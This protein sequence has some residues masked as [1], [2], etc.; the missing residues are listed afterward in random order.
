MSPEHWFL[1]AYVLHPWF[2]DKKWTF[3]SQVHSLPEEELVI[4]LAKV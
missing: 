4:N 3:K 2:K 1:K